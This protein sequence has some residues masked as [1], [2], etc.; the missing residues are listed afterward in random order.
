MCIR[1]SPNAV[2]TVGKVQVYPNASNVIPGRVEF[3]IDIRDFL[4]DRKTRITEDICKFM[5]QVALERGVSVSYQIT[6]DGLPCTSDPS[7][8]AAL[9][10]TCRE[11]DIPYHKM[12]S[13]AYHDSLLVAQFAPVAMIFVPSKDGISHDPAEFTE[14]ED[15][16]LGT[17]V[18]AG[19]LYKLS[20]QE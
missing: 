17:S 19:S 11:Q 14:L 18:L 7:L 4:E 5:D 12:I 15:I 8:V 6:A 9:E 16:V 13:G 2:A 1:D 10:E 3:S 20:N